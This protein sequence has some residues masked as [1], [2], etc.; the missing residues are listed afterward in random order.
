TGLTSP[1][2][3][4]STAL[5]AIALPVGLARR[6]LPLMS[7]VRPQI[8]P[9]GFLSPTMFTTAPIRNWSS[10]KSA[11]NPLP[12]L[13]LAALVLLSNGARAD[14]PV[15]TPT[16]RAESEI[17][18][19]Y[20]TQHRSSDGSSGSSRGRDTLLERVVS[21][22]DGG[23]ELEYDLP[24]GTDA[25]ARARSWQFPVR[26]L[27][28]TDG[29]IKLL[30]RSELEARVETWLKTA[31]LNRDA[32]GTWIFTW[33]AFRIECDPESVIETIEAFNLSYSNLRDGASYREPESGGT[34]TLR[35]SE[36]GP[37][38]A[39][40]SVTLEIDPNAVHR[41]RANEDVATGQILRQ[42]VTLES[43]LLER[44]KESVSGTISIAFDTNI[45]GTAF[46]KTKVT[47][48]ETR[49]LDGKTEVSTVTE[50]VER[51]PI[52]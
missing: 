26:V 17:T 7:D 40:F 18:K 24:R 14:S 32:C 4:Q 45:A 49:R 30:N 41:A 44:A 36:A 21:M 13:A 43:A 19:T 27:R 46:R 6:C 34:G 10:G 22:Q 1:S 20:E 35:I 23:V 33:N 11:G 2:S 15:P 29:T 3:G 5:Q 31:R 47:R 50:T 48:V 8:R 12:M 42:P 37:N 16:V 28:S 25:E 9:I 52:R 51:R 38:G 39:K